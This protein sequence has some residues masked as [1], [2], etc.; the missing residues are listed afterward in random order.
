MLYASNFLILKKRSNPKSTFV[1]L[2]LL[3]VTFA[4]TGIGRAADLVIADNG[5]SAYQIVIP[6]HAQD[7]VVDR[8]LKNTANLMQRAF[9]NN[10]IKIPVV[11]E[12]AQTANKPCIY[13]GATKFAARNHIQ[14]NTDDWTYVWKTVGKNLVIVGSDRKDPD[15]TSS[16]GD[17]IQLALLGTVKGALD[18][19][20]EYAG[21]RFLF[22]DNVDMRLPKTFD[23]NG[24]VPIDTRSIAF[25]PAQRIAI[26]SNLDI[27]K[28]PPMKSRNNGYSN[29]E[30]FYMIAND[31]F[32]AMRSTSTIVPSVSWMNE[33]TVAKYGKTH[34]EYFALLPNGKRASER[35]IDYNPVN[36]RG[37]TPLDVTNPDV[38][39]LIV[40]AIEA[41]IKEGATAIQISP[42]DE[43][44][45]DR[46]N[47][48]KC[49]AFFGLS[50]NTYDEVM[51]RGK[52]GKLWGI[53]FTIANRI[54][55]KYPKIKLLAW[56][57]QD[58]PLDSE[59]IQSV[60]RFPVNL[61]PELHM[62]LMKD[63]DKLQGISIPAGV[64][65]IEE[66][67]T[68][69][70]LD[71][72]YAP[73][74]TPAYAAE[75][76]KAE[77]AN[78]VLFARRDGSMKVWGLQAPAYYVYG[79]MLGDP[80]ADYEDILK[81]FYRTSFGNVAPQMTQFYGLLHDQLGVYSDWI[82]LY[83]PA[84]YSVRAAH[85][86]NN[87][88]YHQ[89]IYT[90]EYMSAA[91][92]Q[93][94]AAEQKAT[95]PDVKA[96]LHLIRIEFDYLCDLSKIFTLQDAWAIHPSQENLKVLLDAVDTWH[97]ELKTL[98]GGIGET[99][100]QPLN[101]WPQMRPFDGDNYR[102]AALETS[103]Y[104]NGQ[105]QN[106]A[107]GWDTGAIRQAMQNDKL[108]FSTQVQATSVSE[109]P[110]INS[111]AWENAPA[112]VLRSG[113][114]ETLSRTTF[115]VLH[116]E[117]NLY[118][119]IDSRIDGQGNVRAATKVLEDL[120]KPKSEEEA[121]KQ[122]YVK[123]AI[124][125]KAGGPTYQFAANPVAGSRYDAVANPKADTSW[126]GQWK[127]AYQINAVKSYDSPDYPSWTA[128][129]Q[130]PFSDL[131][132][133]TPAAK[134]PWKITAMRHGVQGEGDLAWNG[135]MVAN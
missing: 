68:A 34:P 17:T 85:R 56:D 52:T 104:Q 70:N 121:F 122:E 40:A 16:R 27:Q 20:R 74:R 71:G 73:E 88:W 66:T 61:I 64:G 23:K 87:K 97:G 75:M 79:R 114:P 21:V 4:T 130:I 24:L 42:P 14:V 46:C 51:A 83:Q 49:N 39:N 90:S 126:N 99:R 25:E 118:V 129:F 69:F 28:T 48:D 58:T 44:Y 82:G 113:M 98:A 31:Y 29:I 110:D 132:V 59:Y 94:T 57:Y 107:I 93:L 65:A 123:I 13:L 124:Q 55:Q 18:F 67:F 92:A 22:N 6:D 62:G 36:S 105:W 133:T 35:T 86:S 108:T 7:E 84:W 72:P 3:L 80:S 109:I 54:H 5:V 33:I 127:F 53:Y 50:A 96:R 103:F 117:Q 32:P 2:L 128:W 30:N 106:T 11:S 120:L 89:V 131:G 91:N 135:Q 112:E 60:K 19:L 115:K 125:P 81:E 63:F 119:R 37:M 12:S 41:K 8:W 77:V 26:P 43:Y 9:A 100:T 10:G 45:L 76:A 111:V 1:P 38:Q 101:D 102:D 134:E 47:C 15:V 95:D 116:D 78:H